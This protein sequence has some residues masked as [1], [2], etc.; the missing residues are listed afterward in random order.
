MH[1]IHFLVFIMRKLSFALLIISFLLF[2]NSC[3]DTENEILE[4]RVSHHKQTG[5]GFIGP[6][7]LYRIQVEDEI[8]SDEWEVAF[9]IEDFDYEWGYTYDILVAK[10]YYEE[11]LTDAPSFRYI[12]LKDLS[13]KKVEKG[14]Q[15][16]LILKR[17][18]EDDAVESFVEGD[19][20]SGFT[21]LGTKAFECA[22]LCD[23]LTKKR[24]NKTLLTGTF[25]FLEDGKIKLVNLKSQFFR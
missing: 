4:L 18:Y 17:I 13:K 11:H 6:R 21:I 20:E 22:D 9:D 3:Q 8:G 16:D 24:D 7:I 25:E 14:T 1:R 10:K 12:F 19:K 15:F 5:Y 2:L 23:E